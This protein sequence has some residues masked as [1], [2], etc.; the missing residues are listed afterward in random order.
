MGAF[1]AEKKY[2]KNLEALKQEIEE[3]TR[4]GDGLRLEVKGCHD[5]YNRLDYE[6][7]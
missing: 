2:K 6:K 3:K 7:K 1:D 5:K 4:E